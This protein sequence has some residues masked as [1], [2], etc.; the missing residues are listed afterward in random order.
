MEGVAP[1]TWPPAAASGH[2]SENIFTSHRITSQII[3][4]RLKSDSKRD[5]DYYRLIRV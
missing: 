5:S 2:R 4:A 1:T 3:L